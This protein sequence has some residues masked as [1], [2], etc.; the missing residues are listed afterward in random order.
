MLSVVLL[1]TEYPQ[2]ILNWQPNSKFFNLL[3]TTEFST[4]KQWNV[5]PNSNIRPVLEYPWSS[6]PN[7][8]NAC[9]L[10]KNTLQHKST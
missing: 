8:F 10:P 4:I 2:N 7:L 3:P 6:S 9:L 1:T 5:I